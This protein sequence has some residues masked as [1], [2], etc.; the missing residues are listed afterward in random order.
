MLYGGN[1]E[2]A[3][4][5]LGLNSEKGTVIDVA[6]LQEMHDLLIREH[7]VMQIPFIADFLKTCGV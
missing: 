3:M 1:I 6:I 7:Q 4:K 2:E 5:D